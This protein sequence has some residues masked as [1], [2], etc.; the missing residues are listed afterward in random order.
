M[1]SCGFP[2]IP[3][4]LE[5]HDY[6]TDFI[7]NAEVTH[8]WTQDQ[9]TSR[10]IALA[11]NIKFIVDDFRDMIGKV[12]GVLLARDDAEMHLHYS[13]PFLEAGIPIYIDKP[14]ALTLDNAKQ[15]IDLQSYPGQLFSCSALRYAQELIL[16]TSQVT[17][18]GEV[19]YVIG[20]SPKNWDKYSIHLIEPILRLF[21]EISTNVI[22]TSRWASSNRVVL[23]GECESG[24][25]FEIATMGKCTLPISFKIVGEHHSVELAFNN[26]FEAFKA[27]LQTFV[28]YTCRKIEAISSNQMLACIA[29]VEAGRG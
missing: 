3:R 29:L 1:E 27:A 17:S 24:L 25:E 7:N 11:A 5:K 28:D 21:P 2:V 22:L 14:L 23:H 8:V 4:Y 13:R 19:K 10:H 12:D 20:C 26:T 6:P 18:L 9:D 15:M 16:S